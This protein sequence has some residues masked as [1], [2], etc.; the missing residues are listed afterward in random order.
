MESLALQQSL[1]RAEFPDQQVEDVVAYL[2]T[3]R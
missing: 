1:E 3:L 2:L